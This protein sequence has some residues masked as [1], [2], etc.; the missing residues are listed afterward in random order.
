MTRLLFI[1]LL[2]NWLCP[3]HAQF[4]DNNFIYYG[5]DLNLGNYFGVNGHLDY[6][7]QSKYSFRIGQTMSV[8][9]AR[10]QPEDYEKGLEH[11]LF[12]FPNEFD[13]FESYYLSAGRVIILDESKTL[14]ANLSI[15][16]GY[17]T[18]KEPH[19]WEKVIDPELLYSNYTFQTKKYST[20]SLILNPDIE[21]AFT[22]YFGVIL[23]P[24]V[25]INKDRTHFG[26]G[27]GIMTGL[28][29]GKIKP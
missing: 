16:A 15:G 29:R 24:I 23:S 26:I 12:R 13:H 11:G 14:R 8:R 21:F 10:T 5:G 2:T 19:S 28:L 27:I 20:I 6:I 25:E 7:Y 3:V 4:W 17:T 18:I 22:R 1:L 9:R